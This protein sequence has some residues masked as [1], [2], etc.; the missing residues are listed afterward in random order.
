MK[1]TLFPFLI[2]GVL[3]QRLVQG[4]INTWDTVLQ[5]IFLR[6]LFRGR[7]WRLPLGHLFPLCHG[8]CHHN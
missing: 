3:L 1:I 7:R 5:D 4:K 6:L 2:C 8:I